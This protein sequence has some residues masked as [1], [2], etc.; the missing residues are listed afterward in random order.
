MTKAPKTSKNTRANATE[1]ASHKPGR[2]I[3]KTLQRLRPADLDGLLSK[4]GKHPDGGSLYLQ[5]RGGR[6]A[7]VFEKREGTGRKSI[8]LGPYP[9]V[10][11][12]AARKARQAILDQAP[13][14]RRSSYY[15]A[16]SVAFTPAG[17]PAPA[18]RVTPPGPVTG[19]TQTFERVA[20]DFLKARADQYTP[21]RVD[22][23]RQI[24]RLHFGSIAKLPMRDIATQQVADTLRPIWNG[25]ID[26][27]GRKICPLIEKFFTAAQIAPNP[28][29]MEQL[30][31]GIVNGLPA[32]AKA[33]GVS[34]A[35]LPFN[36][37][38]TLMAKLA[39]DSGDVVR[40]IR[41]LILTGV[42]LKEATNATWA[43]ID[44]KAKTWTIPAERMKMDVEHIVP[45]SA[46]ALAV[47]GE[48][49]DGLIFRG[50]RSGGA[51]SHTVGLEHL[52]TYG[53]K[54]SKGKAI[55]LHGFRSS[56]ATWAEEHE[57]PFTP[58]VIH[59]NLAHYS[60]EDRVSKAYLRGDLWSKRVEMMKAWAAFAASAEIA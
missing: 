31:A 26:S 41:F 27:T 16:P 19:S 14:R 50:T 54:D 49:G 3:L 57:P 15:L 24:L 45:L 13:P 47:L 7:W 22:R 32:K 25:S 11:I 37:V 43:E 35:S 8:G 55:T 42:R 18:M 48:R 52:K 39:E 9:E 10:S 1:N 21:A 58:K 28:A 60:K 30:T 6:G 23:F 5:V 56:L 40:M 17:Q 38:P 53:L 46:E 59:F 12:Q 36:Q 4:D 20:D 44:L 29:T 33:K 51:I 2:V 34:V